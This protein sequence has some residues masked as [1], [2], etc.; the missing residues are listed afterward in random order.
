MANGANVTSIGQIAYHCSVA[1]N[2]GADAQKNIPLNCSA[3]VC[4]NE[5][6]YIGTECVYF[7]AGYFTYNYNGQDRSSEMF[8]ATELFPGK[9]WQRYYEYRL[10]AKT[11]AITPI[12]ASNGPDDAHCFPLFIVL[13]AFM[14]IIACR[15]G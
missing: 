9:Y 3:G 12:S 15:R 4:T 2:D 5:P 13:A 10:D 11:G 14:P 6:R 8:N 1:S 7:P